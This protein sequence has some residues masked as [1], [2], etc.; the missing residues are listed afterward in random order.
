MKNFLMQAAMVKPSKRQ[1][2]WFELGGYA[3]IHFGINTFTDREWGNGKED[4]KLFDAQ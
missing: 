1:L 3:F 4:E 2:D